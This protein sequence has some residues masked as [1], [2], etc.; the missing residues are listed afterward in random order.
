MK[1]CSQCEFIYEDDQE[2]CDMDG[3]ELVY[4]PQPCRH[5]QQ[6]AV[7]NR[8]RRGVG[9]GL[10]HGFLRDTASVSNNP[11]NREK[12]EWTPEA[13]IRNLSCVTYSVRC[14]RNF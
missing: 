2:R 6:A 1:L 9:G 12:H 14:G 7:A 11:P 5:W 4:E 3:A 8:R 10:L 13:E